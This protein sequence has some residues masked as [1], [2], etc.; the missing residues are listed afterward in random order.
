MLHIAHHQKVVPSQPFRNIII[1]NSLFITI[2]SKENIIGI[3]SSLFFS[4]IFGSHYFTLLFFFFLVIICLK[5][6]SPIVY[7][8]NIEKLNLQ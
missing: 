4:P 8:A 5:K 2:I 3:K 7:L 1:L 6:K